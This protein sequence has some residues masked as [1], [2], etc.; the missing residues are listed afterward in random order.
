[1]SGSGR[2]EP[3]LV[4]TWEP[5]ADDVRAREVYGGDVL[6]TFEPN[7]TLIYSIV[8]E[9]SVQK[10]L[11]TYRIEGEEIVTDQQSAPHEERSRYV[12]TEDGKLWMSNEGIVSRWVKR[13]WCKDSEH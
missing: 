2:R 12:L 9:K 8:T 1:M 4:G 3:V 11:L 6:L 5:A 13:G 7:G 10:V